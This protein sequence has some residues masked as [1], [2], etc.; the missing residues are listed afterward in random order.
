MIVVCLSAC[1]DERVTLDF[2]RTLQQA[3]VAKGWTQKELATRVN[4]K[5]QVVNDYESGRAIPNQQII[6]KLERAVGVKLRGKDIGAPL[7]S[8]KK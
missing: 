3:R 7:G 1:S 5:P 8:K 4:E 6:S 2:G